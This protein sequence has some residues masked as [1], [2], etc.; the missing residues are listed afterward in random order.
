VPA[1]RQQSF[2][3][4]TIDGD[5]ERHVCPVRIEDPPAEV[6]ARLEG[7][8]EADAEPLAE[9][10]GVAK[11]LPDARQGGA[12]QD[13]LVNAI[14]GRCHHEYATSWLHDTRNLLV[15]QVELAEMPARLRL[16]FS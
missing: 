10:L 4:D 7:T 5:L 15:A 12:Q 1:E 3:L 9:A 2:G 8:V 16:P 6:R 14:G 13:L 11:R